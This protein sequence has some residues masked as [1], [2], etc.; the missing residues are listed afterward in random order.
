MMEGL[1]ISVA[2]HNVSLLSTDKHRTS[3]GIDHFTISRRFKGCLLDVRINRGANI[4]FQGDHH[5]MTAY[6]HVLRPQLLAGL[7]SCDFLSSTS[8]AC[9]IHLLLDSVRAI[10][11]IGCLNSSL[12]ISMSIGSPSSRVLHRSWATFRRGVIISG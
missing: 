2:C 11:L 1:R 6:A 8:N 12:R 9:M 3:N 5:L 4:S 10:L 7:E